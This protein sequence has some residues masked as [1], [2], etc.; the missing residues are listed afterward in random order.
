MRSSE[1]FDELL[2]ALGEARGSPAPGSGQPGAVSRV[3]GRGRHRGATAGAP[4]RCPVPPEPGTRESSARG[5]AVSPARGGATAGTARSEP[6]LRTPVVLPL[7]PVELPLARRLLPRSAL[8]I[9]ARPRV[10]RLCRACRRAAAPCRGG[11]CGALP[12]GYAPCPGAAPPLQAPR[13]AWCWASSV[14]GTAGDFKLCFL[15]ASPRC[16]CHAQEGGGGCRLQT[17]RGDPPGR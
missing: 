8:G 4:L 10:C 3:G 6:H 5:R 16:Q 13:S 15:P 17:P 9:F 1:N 2:K 7:A 12:E 14:P 11:L